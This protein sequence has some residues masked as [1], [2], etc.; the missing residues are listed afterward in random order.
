MAEVNKRIQF[1]EGLT[2]PA[3]GWF[4]ISLTTEMVNSLFLFTVGVGVGEVSAGHTPIFGTYGMIVLTVLKNVLNRMNEWKN[5]NDTPP[6][7]INT[8]TTKTDPDSFT[9]SNVTITK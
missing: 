2:M 1:F 8:L 9:E 3:W 6:N 5:K 7:S 4:I